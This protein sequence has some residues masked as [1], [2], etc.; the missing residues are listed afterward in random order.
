MHWPM[1]SF[2]NSEITRLTDSLGAAAQPGPPDWEVL[3]RVFRSAL[4]EVWGWGS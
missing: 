1:I 2:L 3:N 4:R